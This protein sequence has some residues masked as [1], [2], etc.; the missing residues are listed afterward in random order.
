M[1]IDRTGISSLNAGAGEITYS[2]NE[3][4]KSPDQ[5][6][7]AQADPQVVEMYQQY[8]FEMEEQGMQPVSFREFLDQIM[9][10]SRMAEGGIARLGYASGQRVGF[11]RGALADTKSGKAMSPGTSASGGRRGPS[12]P[13]GGGDPG[14]TYTPPPPTHTGGDGPPPK[15]VWNVGTPSMTFNPGLSEQKNRLYNIR[16]RQL[17][18]Y[19]EGDEDREIKEKVDDWFDTPA[20]STDPLNF[21]VLQGPAL[22]QMRTLEKKKAAEEYGGPTF[23]PQDQDALD[24]LKKMDADPDNT[25][26]MPILYSAEGGIARLGYANGQRVGFFQGALADTKEGK[27]MS[28]GTS[29]DYSPGQGHRETRETHGGP[30]GITTTPTYIPPEGKDDDGII[31]KIV[32]DRTKAMFNA[33]LL[34]P[35]QKKRTKKYRKAYRDYL[36]SM[37]ITPPSSLDDEDLSNFWVNDAFSFEPGAADAGM[38]EAMDY[39]EFLLEK[40][41]NP[42]VK[43]RGDLGAYKREMGLDGEGQGITSQYPYPYQTASASAPVDETETAEWTAPVIPVDPI[44]FAADGGRMGYAGG[45]IADLRQGYFLGKLV[46]K[47]GRALKK[48]AKSPIGRMGLMALGGW[49]LNQFAPKALG[50]GWVGKLKGL[51]QNN[52]WLGN[53]LLNQDKNKFSPWKLGIGAASLYPLIKGMGD[54][55]DDDFTQTDL[56]KR[57]LAQKQG[58][59]KTFA[60]VGDATN[61]QPIRF[62]DGGRTGYDNGGS[63]SDRY[64]IKIK[65]LMDKGLSRELAEALVLSELSPDAYKILDKKDGGRIGYDNGGDVMMASAPSLEDSLND[66]SINIFKKPY[67]ELTDEEKE[68]LHEINMD[69]V[70]KPTAPQGIMMAAQGGRI[71]YAEGGDDEEDHRSAA[72]SAMYGLRKNAQEGG[73][74]D[75]G[76]M[77]KDYRNEGGFVPIGGQ[78]RADDVPARLSKNEFVFTADAVRNAGGGDID[79]GAEIMENLMENLENGG[80]VSEE[81]QGLEGARNMFATSQRLEGVL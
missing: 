10:E 17:K 75:M 55:E 15:D 21:A 45:G 31:K 47:A 44:R 81:S 42:T 14:M 30:P 34:I 37:G 76:G 33:S 6:L 78:E 71:G 49:G 25:Y 24:K 4:P 46:K 54:D 48:V 13:P 59:D 66:M 61:W 58:W 2:G 9:A 80:K 19:L 60:P 23:T 53:L 18:N 67:H 38:P 16:Q 79:K 68:I 51:A 36:I 56:Y 26:T 73:L 5:Q 12:G 43:Y 39:G 1:A 8:V 35:G 72:L 57:W 28:P 27:A 62:A 32:D 29:A 20:K 65:E 50:G 11:F 41:N 63:A 7:M 52:K 40:F 3:G 22:M 77:E 70:A 74:M 69:L 64:E